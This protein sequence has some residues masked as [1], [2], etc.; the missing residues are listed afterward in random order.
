MA[1][2]LPQ[3]EAAPVWKA[4]EEISAIPRCS[5]DEGR[6]MEFLKAQAKALG[7]AFRQDGVGN[8]VIRKPGSPGKE[9]QSPV[10]LQGH[11]DMVCEKNRD[12]VHDFTCDPISLKIEDGW[13]KAEGT[14]LGAD[15]GIA[16][17]MM[18]ALLRDPKA[19][20]PPLECLLT[21]DEETALTGALALDPTL[22]TGKTLINIDSEDEGRFCIGCA[23]GL[24]AWGE[25]DLETAPAGEEGFWLSLRGLKGGHSGTM[26]HEGRGNALQ[27]GLRIAAAAQESLGEKFTLWAFEGGDKHNAI[28]R[29][30]FLGVQGGNLD[31][32]KNLVQTQSRTFKAELGKWGTQLTVSV[33]TPD[34]PE[35]TLTPTATARVIQVLSLIPHGIATM[36]QA[37]PGLV[38]SSSNLAAVKLEKGILKVLTSH[39]ADRLTLRDELARRT[40][41][42]FHLAGGRFRS[43][44]GYPAWSPNPASP[45]LAKCKELWKSTTGSEAVVE[46]IHAGLECGVI[47]DKVPGMDMISLGPDIRDAHTPDERLD[48]GSTLRVWQ[49]LKKLLSELK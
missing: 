6:I 13:L 37:V 15:N 38:E 16:V 18:L 4:F 2:L 8:L 14:T 29:E 7:L 25:V 41:Q 30:V 20:H 47:G 21:V 27:L 40:A 36:S 1:L 23:G 45:L 28:P 3:D 35:W 5:R 33:D 9:H 24:T 26:I 12:T 17:A 48:L 31:F 32:W 19:V 46:L 42:A 34:M 22:M 39:R 11:V 49:F 43:G 44:D 10:V